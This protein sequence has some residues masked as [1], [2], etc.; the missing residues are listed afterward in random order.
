MRLDRFLANHTDYSRSEIGRLIRA[1]RVQVNERPATRAAKSVEPEADTIALDNQR[2]LPFEHLYL[3]LHKPTGYVC[4][5]QDSEHPTVIDLLAQAELPRTQLQA[6]QIAGRLDMDTTGLVLLT[7]DGQWN[8]RLTAPRSECAKRYRVQLA[9]PI[10]STAIAE[11]K[12]G[13]RLRND[14][15]PTLPAELT[16]LGETEAQLVI[17]EGRY[18]QV[19]RM[20]AALGNRVTAL[21][22]ES[23]GHIVL[24]PTLKEGHYR[25]LTPV[26][27]QGI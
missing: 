6:L 12:A 8:H 9:E 22:R 15:E 2:I 25:R 13:I 16:L 27:I 5:N 1:G 17:H 7:T 11:F 10:A 26:E 19:K 3:M 18:H 4:A 20:F 14:D 24:D 23:I 21:H